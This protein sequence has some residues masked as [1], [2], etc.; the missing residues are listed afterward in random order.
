M[1]D[2]DKEGNVHVVELRNRLIGQG[3]SITESNLWNIPNALSLA[4][5]ALTPALV[6]LL[7]DDSRIKNIVAVIVVGIC[8]LT[9]M[10]DGRIARRRGQVTRIGHFLDPLADKFYISTALIMLTYLGRISWL[11]PVLII[12][13]EVGITL[14]RIYAESRG[15]SV[16]ASWLGKT[17]AVSQLIAISVIIIHFSLGGSYFHEQILIWI[18]VAIT[19][20]SGADYLIRSEKILGQANGK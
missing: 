7:M 8:G 3:R 19:L 18:A 17:K 11:V 6:F 15:V 2:R 9:D 10:L 13:R 20:I 16:P 4:R 1:R 5:I 14:F 12:S